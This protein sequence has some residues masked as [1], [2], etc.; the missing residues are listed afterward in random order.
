MPSAPRWQRIGSRNMPKC[1][2]VGPIA[3]DFPYRI[4]SLPSSGQFI[5]ATRMPGRLGGTGANVARALVSRNAAV[6]MVG[7]VGQ[8][9]YGE[10]SV[11]DM[12][13]RGIDVSQIEKL[14]GQT[15]QV[16]LFLEPSGERT[17]VGAAEDNLS[18]IT[19]PAG[20]IS[21]GDLVYFAAWREEFEPALRDIESAGGIVACVPFRK[22]LVT[23]PV[24]YVIGSISEVPEPASDIWAKYSSWTGDKLKYM[25]L[26]FGSRGV[27]LLSACDSKE[28]P[29]VVVQTVDTT[30]AGDAF[31]AAILAAILDG[32]PIMSGV[33]DGLV[34]GA[35][36]AQKE[37][38]I[39]PPWPDVLSAS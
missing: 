4:P 5:Q 13:A 7:Y 25:V 16:L 19:I 2:I 23:L 36:T 12:Q 39:P 15:S 1:W 22:P 27:Q 35:A 11:Q 8:D 38:S 24:S 29:A 30:G 3:W 32:R 10:R 9:K 6:G 28:L 14:P 17:I 33:Q 20:A 37:G 26:T 21:S 34:W 31:A 18:Q